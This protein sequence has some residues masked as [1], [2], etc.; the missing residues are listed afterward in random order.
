MHS[1]NPADERVSASA[2]GSKVPVLKHDPRS[3]W[4]DARSGV[5]G[6]GG[7]TVDGEPLRLRW[8]K[9]CLWIDLDERIRRKP[10]PSEG[11]KVS[12]AGGAWT[13][14]KVQ[15][16]AKMR[17]RRTTSDHS[18]SFFL[19]ELGHNSKKLLGFGALHFDTLEV[20]VSV[21]TSTRH[22]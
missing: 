14:P 7:Q 2:T 19:Y 11:D 18:Q 4:L 3:L 10:F 9:G 21:Y 20:K 1:R 22:P 17:L 15:N 5:Q 8:S 12:A 16:F 6:T 13:I